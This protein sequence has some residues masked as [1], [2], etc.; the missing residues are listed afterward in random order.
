MDS[1]TGSYSKYMNPSFFVNPRH[2]VT[3][4]VTDHYEPQNERNSFE[5]YKQ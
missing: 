4:D 2:M 3:T 1:R 5:E